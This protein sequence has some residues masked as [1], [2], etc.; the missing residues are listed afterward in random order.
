M[1]AKPKTKTSKTKSLIP[2][3]DG[4]KLVIVESP[5]KARTVGQILGKQYVVVASRGHVRD[6]PHTE[7]A[8]RRLH[9]TPL[10]RGGRRRR[11]RRPPRARAAP[12]AAP[13]GVRRALPRRRPARPVGRARAQPEL[14]RVRRR[15]I[16]PS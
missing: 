8:G 3:A 5:A 10:V 9:T 11:R 13:G 14:R 4:K 16:E 15:R 7:A 1:V 12:P 2:S 6:L